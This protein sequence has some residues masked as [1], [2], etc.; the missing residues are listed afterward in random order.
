MDE[1]DVWR[2]ARV[3]VRRHGM[4][5]EFTASRRVEEMTVAGDR[6]GEAHWKRILRAVRDL[7]R[8]KPREDE[9]VN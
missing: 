8:L 4:Y 5:A 3:I 2:A 7:Q 6:S 1:Q 9:A